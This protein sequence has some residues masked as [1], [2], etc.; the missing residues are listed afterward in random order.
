MPCDCVSSAMRYVDSLVDS[1]FLFTQ[2]WRHGQESDCQWPVGWI[3][4]SRGFYLRG[5]VP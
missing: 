4:I 3:I 1:L 2:K 5:D